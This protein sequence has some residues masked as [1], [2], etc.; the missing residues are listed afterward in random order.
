MAFSR[1]NNNRRSFVIP[2]STV[3]SNSAEKTWPKLARDCNPSGRTYLVGIKFEDF[4]DLTQDQDVQKKDKKK[5]GDQKLIGTSVFAG[6]RFD[7]T[8]M[9]RT[10]F[11]VHE[12]TLEVLN[13]FIGKDLQ[14][15]PKIL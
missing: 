11:P 2:I 14:P 4:V 7:K 10:R 8:I 12:F 13:S 9:V 3:E 6:F 5:K 15:N 1:A